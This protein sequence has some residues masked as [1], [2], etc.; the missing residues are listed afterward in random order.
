VTPSFVFSES[1]NLPIGTNSSRHTKSQQHILCY[2][3]EEARRRGLKG[4]QQSLRAQPPLRL[5]GD[6][7]E[8]Q[9]EHLLQMCRGLWSSPC[10][11]FGW[12][13]SLCRVPQ[14]QVSWLGR[15]SYGVLDPSSSFS[16]SL[17]SS[18]RLPEFCLM[19]GYGF[20]HPFPSAPGS[21]LSKD[22]YARFLSIN[23]AEY[24]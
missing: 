24:H 4:R 21:T 11:S 19:F 15:S 17:N 8:D 7:Q 5:L 2:W 9:A 20:L 10:M 16:T 6:P 22:D 12:W 1:G 13:F 3:A 18:S 14:A 23:I